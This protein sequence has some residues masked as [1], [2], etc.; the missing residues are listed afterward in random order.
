MAR[1]D[2]LQA[3][4]EGH[5]GIAILGEGN[6]AELIAEYQAAALKAMQMPAVVERIDSTA[7]EIPEGLERLKELGYRSV[8]VGHPF[9][10]VAAR[11]AAH[12]YMVKHSLGTANALMLNGGVFAQNTE[13]TAFMKT[14]EGIPPATALVLGAGHSARSVVMALLES[15]WKV[16]LWSRSAL[17]A[18]P[19][20]LL[21]Q[22]YGTIELVPSP[23]PVGAGLIVNATPLGLRPGEI[24]PLNWNHV[25]R[26]AVI[27][28]LV[29]RR[30][31][32]EL[33]RAA[34]L[35]GLKT[36]GGKEL[37]IE[38]AAQALEW[39]TGKPV[40]REAM[41]AQ[42]VKKDYTL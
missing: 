39:W 41:R 14:L 21:L 24:P 28:D 29:V 7:A 30:V 4:P 34:S 9:K 3:V 19:L 17:K 22:R 2:E 12:F 31:N 33:V 32:T 23:D 15:G 42:S 10:P 6:D 16:R 40:P 35:R 18:K 38:Q 11:L 27:I 5:L 26:G 13:V 20:I 36:V 25:Q 1:F 37:L 8:N